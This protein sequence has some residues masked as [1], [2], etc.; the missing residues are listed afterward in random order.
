MSGCA[1]E[2][3][4]HL[5]VFMQSPPRNCWIGCGIRFVS[6]TTPTARKHPTSSGFAALSCFTISGIPKR[7]VKRHR[8]LSHSS[9]CR[10]VGLCFD[11]KSSPQ[12]LAVSLSGSAQFGNVEHRCR[13]SKTNSVCANRVDQTGGNRSD[14]AA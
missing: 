1:I 10:G 7:W 4:A 8:S 6:S 11:T 3:T 12:C 13:S 2:H 9:S 5:L 14:S